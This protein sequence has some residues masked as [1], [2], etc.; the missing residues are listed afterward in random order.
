MLCL[1]EVLEEADVILVEAPA[2]RE[3]MA[4][5]EA[6]V[7][8]EDLAVPEWA[9]A[10]EGMMAPECRRPRRAEEADV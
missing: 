10:E 3:V 5:M 6:P 4:D 2:V 9:A 8:R 1:W 7:A